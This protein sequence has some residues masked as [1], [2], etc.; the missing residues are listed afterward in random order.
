MT[1]PDRAADRSAARDS[2]HGLALGDAFGERWFPLFRHGRPRVTDI[3]ARR[4]PGDDHWPWTDDTALALGVWRVLDTH[5]EIDQ[6][7][8]ARTFGRLFTADPARGYGSGM[9]DLLPRL[10]EEPS[11]WREA[12]RG[13]F[14]GQGSL[15]NG[16]AMRVAPLGAWF[17]ADLER[18]AEQAARSAEVTHAH[19]DGVAG[20]VAV[21]L[22]A[23]LAARR[24][25]PTPRPDALLRQV[26]ER[27]PGGGVRAGLLRAA[28]LPPETT[29]QGAAHV[30][31]SGA[32]IRADD[33][34][35]FAL[36]CAARH[37]DDLVEAL[38][39]TA[40]GLGD[41][42]TTCA[43]AGGVVA[44]RTGLDAVPPEWL[45]RREPLPEWVEEGS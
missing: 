10:A 26:A 4:L 5:G 3:R 23:A 1:S 11:A 13:L 29:P 7:D 45:A 24:D 22:A 37:L 9:H 15:G 6:T 32:R 33:T 8:L 12:A 2:I 41:V 19:P 14:G 17:R 31:G 18:V 16:A 40:E 43:I 30:L 44:A 39:A 36:W 27:T 42:D 38:W 25:Q 28:A 35:P 20:A 21:A 34:V